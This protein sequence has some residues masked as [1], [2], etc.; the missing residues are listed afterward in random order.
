MIKEYISSSSRARSIMASCLMKEATRGSPGSPVEKP[1]TE[2]GARPDLMQDGTTEELVYTEAAADVL[3]E[4][5]ADVLEE[6]ATDVLEE[7]AADVLEEE[8]KEEFVDTG[9]AVLKVI[10]DIIRNVSSLHLQ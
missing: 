1:E 3:E 4:A 6:A 10:I 9:A 2:A 5:A 8:K 7:A